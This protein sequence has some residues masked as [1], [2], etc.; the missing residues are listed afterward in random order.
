MEI[1]KFARKSVCLLLSAGM[2]VTGLP[3]KGVLE[4]FAVQY[5]IKADGM[6]DKASSL[7]QLPTIVNCVAE[8]SG[9]QTPKEI[10]WEINGGGSFQNAGSLV[11]VTGTIKENG[12][13][14][15][16]TVLA[17]PDD[18][19][20]LVDA[21]VLTAEASADYKR[22]KEKGN[23]SALK[24]TVPDQAYTEGSWGYT[25]VLNADLSAKGAVPTYKDTKNYTGYYGKNGNP[26][27]Y[28]LPL[29]AGTY[30]VSGEFAEWWGMKRAIDLKVTYKTQ[31]GL[32]KTDTLDTSVLGNGINTDTAEGN[33]TIDSD[34]E[35]TLSFEK[36]S[37]GGEEAVLSGFTVLKA[38]EELPEGNEIAV[39]L[40][41]SQ[42][43]KANTFGGFGSVTCNNTSRLLMDYKALHEDK[44]W[45]MMH[46]LFD[47]DNGA[48]LNHVK[49][50]MGA[51]VNSSSGT[52]P[53]TM[54]S[55]DETPNVKR[56]AGFVFAADA[57]SIN[58]DISVEILRWG[59]PR[60]TQEGI[61][62]EDYENPKFEARYQWYRKTIDAVFDTYGYKITEVSP[63]QNER[64]K[65]YPDDFAWIKY[66]A[67]RFKEDGRNGIGAF[68]YG[69]IKIVAADLYRGMN[70]TVD[71]LMK[72]AELRD[73][74]DVISDHYQI[75]MGSPDLTKLNQEYGKEIL[76]GES[77]AP[78]INAYY[79][80]N[81]DPERGGVGGSA[82]I[83]AMAERFIA[84]YAYKNADGYT[85][86]MTEL[87]FQPAIGAFYEG[88]AYS[89]KQLIGAFDP[90]SGYYEADGGIQMVQHFMQFADSDWNYLPDACYSDGTTG[91][92]DITVDTS[93]DTRLAVKDPESDDYSVVFANNTAKERK[94]RLTLKNLKTAANP[95]NVWETR[96]PEASQAF[97][98][99]WFQNIVKEG[100]PVD[101][102]DGTST[103]ELTVKPYSVLTLTSLL[104]RGTAYTIGQSDSGV[105]RSVLDLPYRD[106]F[107]YKGFGDSFLE[108]RGGTP[109]FTT[110]LEGAFEVTK[111]E[112]TGNV[113]TQIINGDN[114]PYNWNPWG[115]GSDE[116][117]QT[118][119]TPW[120]VMGDHRWANYTAGIDVKLDT[121]GNG[122]GDNFAVLGARELV[123]S[124][125]AAYQAR[126]F[127]S[128]KWELLK[129]N[130][131]KKSGKI[132]N[133]DASVWHKLQL[134]ADENVITMYVDGE[135]TGNFTDTS[136]PVMTGRVALKSG[137]WNTSFDNL[138]VMPIKD[139]TPYAS[140]KI[141]DTS[142]LISWNGNVTHNIGQGFA[143]YNRSYTS[144]QAGSSLEFQIPK[145]VGFDLFG[146]SGSAGIEVA[147][148]NHAP[149]S[150]VAS[151][152]GDRETFYWREDLEN[153]PHT[154]KV[155][156]TNGTL[157]LDGINLLTEP[158]EEDIP[159]RIEELADLIHFVADYSFDPDKY[160]ET[161]IQQLKDSLQAAQKT[162]DLQE[163][164]QKV[165]LSRISLRNAFIGV[166]PGD[167]LVS[168]KDLPESVAVIQ[169]STPE[170]PDTVTVVNAA[171]EEVRKE[172][173]WDIKESEFETLWNTVTVIGK[174]KDTVLKTSVKAVV[175]PYGLEWFIDSGTE[176]ITGNDGEAGHSATYDLVAKSVSLKNE[177]SDKIY[178]EG[179]WGYVPD[180][181]IVIKGADSITYQT[182]VYESG[183]FV[184]NFKDK[185]IVYNV[186]LD[187]GDYRFMVGS[188]AYWSETHSSA[189]TVGYKTETGDWKTVDLGTSTV[190]ASSN[191]VS[192]TKS[193]NIPTSGLVE[194]RIKKANTKIHLLSWLAIA[195]DS[196]VK[197]PSAI[198]TEKDTAP[199]LPETVMVNGEEKNVT[200]KNAGKDAFGKLWSTV[201]VKGVVDELK[202]PVSV[203]VEVVPKN[204]VYFVDSGVQSKEE[205]SYYAL[206]S[207]T[208]K[209]LL[210]EVPDK[211]YEEGSW[212]YEDPEALGGP[213]GAG[214]DSR[215]K[216]G[217]WAKAGK[218]VVY[219]LP[220][221]AGSY[222]FTSGFYEWWNVSRPM[223][224]YVV[225]QDGEGKE[226]A[227][228]LGNITISTSQE[229]ILNGKP[230]IEL[231]EDQTVE[232]HV[233][234]TGSSDPVISWVAVNE[235]K[236]EL[237]E[238]VS[239][240]TTG[241][242]VTQKPDKMEYEPGQQLDTAGMEVRRNEKATP[243]NAVR[244]IVMDED[245]Y[246]VEYDFS[247]PG[248]ADVVVSYSEW[249]ENGEEKV[250]TDSF[251][252]TVKKEV[253]EDEYYTTRIEVTKKP[254]KTLYK[255]GETLDTEGLEVTEYE[256]ASPSNATR[257]THL[258]EDVYDLEYDF[259]T[260]GNK[261]VKV[262]Y[263]G[264]DKRGEERRFTDFFAVC[265]MN[266]FNP[267]SSKDSDRSD[268][269]AYRGYKSREESYRCEGTWIEDEKGWKLIAKDGT[270][271][272]NRWAIVNWNGQDSWY[273]FDNK[274][275]I[276][277]SWFEYEGSIYYLNP[278]SGSNKGRMMTGW[279]EI[280]GKWYYFNEKSD[281]KKGSMFKNTVT[282]D[283]YKV[284]SD[285]AWIR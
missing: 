53:A 81:V 167:T 12:Q 60:W 245:D 108:E 41:G 255:V 230:V 22:F 252:V 3:G 59:E 190:S 132:E 271:P 137:F 263:Y 158:F 69:E 251:R 250:F 95:Y 210:N 234:K 275:Y 141:D 31:D 113:L 188:Q 44:Y 142:S 216:T 14:E 48:G 94:Y 191:N 257:K 57:K 284:G 112:D 123:H 225:Y 104:D 146:K 82:S 207:E 42:I 217:W 43:D 173:V 148:D 183:L 223:E 156:V 203:S 161:L 202:I 144:M 13:K 66:C 179:S 177:R 258:T 162:L 35:I 168:V 283:G 272:V 116:S 279:Q 159:V 133:F 175:I 37:K 265:V 32:I 73:L 17:V 71:Y 185:D 49:I 4:T 107:E 269:D 5:E 117:S 213:M 155:K 23:A 200:W 277:T 90:W 192:Y 16:F 77:T 34:Q 128:G 125:G 105:E 9:I 114:R 172:V 64:R 154:V 74:V 152:S 93:T 6:L 39:T 169:N 201:K 198:V 197:M 80:A 165:D 78:M 88:S 46:L 96:G 89:P 193:V 52:E 99:N 75:W 130:S 110:D 254:R 273:F 246:E 36:Q 8:G 268:H 136:S 164:Q 267:D 219:R 266:V 176:N 19:V 220:L 11:N 238:E 120:T 187:A 261:N 194:V 50:E 253:V 109:L 160:P 62:F 241:I 55:P 27:T 189:I 2:V 235:V 237:P 26:I 91:D 171:G 83:A 79:R 264:I 115:S 236:E 218:D 282:P 231:P 139:K 270:S 182:G 247:N 92:G 214:S 25:G 249:D 84:A 58:P 10:T 280:S 118:T 131:V 170:L 61:G 157:N 163:N 243:S 87:L 262:V 30:I 281:G 229:Y 276:L 260:A 196:S 174:I 211:Q 233:R 195:A 106:N 242:K 215:S 20:Y 86:H 227:Q 143:F 15:N 285:G 222:Q 24:N 51:D 33:F 150:A 68:D 180:D 126:I 121:K 56:G 18:V 134:K 85:S 135:E 47:K 199:E 101:N 67:K 178:E 240:H 21:N 232:F 65:D 259:S 184:D 239:Y 45:Q 209:G 40:D 205:S 102:G 122:Y 145:G 226:M 103:I 278:K 76:Y 138:E 224:A 256:K 100:T 1:K 129:Y 97:D 119:G 28:K 72:D 111:S 212:G 29:E 228:T 204:L 127:D 63:G 124:K 153:K 140:S 208:V 151:D 70:T 181:D 206:L 248:K 186:N 166:V 54:R 221:K 7:E 147:I 274:G 149:V 98:A 244:E 38:K